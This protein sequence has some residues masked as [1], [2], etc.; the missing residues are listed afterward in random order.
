MK[1]DWVDAIDELWSREFSDVPWLDQAITIWPAQ[2]D[3]GQLFQFMVEGGCGSLSITPGERR[4]PQGSVVDLEPEL[5]ELSQT[6]DQLGI[7]LRVAPGQP[8]D[9]IRIEQF[10]P[11]HRIARLVCLQ[12]VPAE[13]QWEVIYNSIDRGKQLQADAQALINQT[14]VPF[15]IELS[16]FIGHLIAGDHRGA[17]WVFEKSSHLRRQQARL[18]RLTQRFEL[19]LNAHGMKRTFKF[20][21]ESEKIAYLHGAGRLI[22]AL[23]KLSPYVSLGF[24]AVLGYVRDQD[25]IGH[26][27]DL[28]VLVGFESPAVADLGQ[29]LELTAQALR[30]AGFE[31]VGHFFSHLW[32]KTPGGQRADVF[33]GLI[34]PDDTL[35]FYPSARRSLRPSDV[36]PTAEGALYGVVLP[37][38]AH[39]ESYLR[40]TYGESWR[41]PDIG[42]AH[43]WDRDD[44]A[45]IAGTRLVPPTSTRGEVIRRAR[46][47]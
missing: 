6:P 7:L 43:P 18:Q 4:G 36:F 8:V 26:D 3:R 46:G 20:W 10:S 5:Y 35:S 1:V 9:C 17:V 25:L 34:E 11:D 13:G 38:P 29:A 19:Q 47:A 12:H 28:D 16:S 22:Q 14:K 23:G 32:V 27:D 39:C 2:R 30:D 21:R 15:K 42:F 41:E 45:D 33:V 31:V 40:K 44:Y 37:M 24:G